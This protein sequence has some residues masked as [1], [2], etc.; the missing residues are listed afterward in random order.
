[1]ES[2][3]RSE[4]TVGTPRPRGGPARLLRAAIAAAGFAILLYLAGFLRF[5]TL[6]ERGP[7]DPASLEAADGIVALTGG[8]ERIAAA[9]QLLT[10]DKGDRLLISG[11]HRNVTRGALKAI[12]E[13]PGQKFDCCVDIGW[14]AENTIGNAEETAAWVARQQFRS[15]IV[16]TSAYHMPRS[17]TELQRALPETDL[18][19]YPVY[20]E[21]VH[22]DR[23]WAYSGT[24]RLLLSEYTKYLLTLSRLRTGIDT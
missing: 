22:L 9:M 13:D 24:T 12:V 19:P 15:I 17:L 2:T 6:I 16:V 21:S 3:I 5:M 23:W 4:D 11:V 7:I 14:R 20:Q 8:P 1:M 10:A 18:R